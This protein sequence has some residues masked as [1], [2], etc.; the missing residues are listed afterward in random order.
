ML[1]IDPTRSWITIQQR[2][3]NEGDGFLSISLPAMQDSFIESL[4][5]G[6]WVSSRLWKERL[7]GPV[8]LQEYLRLIFDYGSSD[9]ELRN[10]CSA[11]AVKSVR[12]ILGLNGKVKALPSRARQDKAVERFFSNEEK[13]R[14]SRKAI[15]EA[16]QDPIFDRVVSVLLGQVFSSAEKR[17]LSDSFHYK[18]G[19]GST[20]GG[21]FGIRKWEA[22]RKGWTSRLERQFDVSSLYL[23]YS[24]L[25]SDSLLTLP[26]VI[27]PRDEPPMKVTLVPKTAKTPR[28]IAME[29]PAMQWAQQ[30]IHGTLL[31]TVLSQALPK[32][33]IDWTDQ[34]RNRS[35][36]RIGSI[37]GELSTL[38]LSDASDL[39]HVSVVSRMLRK[40]RVLRD[41]TFACRT[42]TADFNGRLVRLEKFAPMGSALCFPFET[43]AFWVIAT[44]GALR[45]RRP[46][47]ITKRVILNTARKISVYGDDIIAPTHSAP[48]IADELAR[49][50]LVVNGRKSFWNGNFRESCGADFFR[51]FDVTYV[52]IRDE[53][54]DNI[55]RQEGLASYIETQNRF[56]EHGFVVTS[57]WMIERSPVRLASF[58]FDQKQ[59]LVFLSD[60]YSGVSWDERL[61]VIIGK[62]ATRRVKHTTSSQYEQ[63]RLL[64]WF[65]NKND[66]PQEP[67]LPLVGRSQVVNLRFRTSPL[68]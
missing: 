19:P 23:T 44:I 43:M 1:Q 7:G 32:R 63:D 36:A 60:T 39:L 18:H 30:H 22:A 68:E 46:D 2:F 65:I 11:F 53:I 45:A 41:A 66:E 5:T 15:I 24:D 55:G 67:I 58:R 28:I 40:H 35:L 62:M 21:Y 3:E 4:A 47:Q 8:F 26:G 14:E 37:D 56:F 34:E 51:G 50:G 52:K 59:E 54:P 25:A 16:T 29:P 49:F 6:R 33:S 42:T 12:Q 57:E 10:D 64:N 9:L 17:L 48:D 38:D 13:L 20:S 31:E 61:F 27:S